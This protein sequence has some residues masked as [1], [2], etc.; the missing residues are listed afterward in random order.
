MKDPHRFGEGLG[1][2]LV[3]AALVTAGLSYLWQHGKRR[4]AIAIA[5]GVV[6][7]ITAITWTL[8][9]TFGAGA[10]V[11]PLT[12]AERAPLTLSRGKLEHPTLHFTLEAPGVDFTLAGDEGARAIAAAMPGRD[13]VTGWLYRCPA[14]GEAVLV[15]LF[16]SVL[17]SRQGLE[18]LVDGFR[19]SLL[20]AGGAAPTLAGDGVVWTASERSASFTATLPNGPTVVCRFV[21]G[22]TYVAGVMATLADTRRAEDLAGSLALGAL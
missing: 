3:F 11:T 12:A 13:D 5:V 7:L 1:R 10:T 15:M 18:G 16:K 20:S 22:P 21:A 6:A 19:Q 9:G 17:D 14:T 8:L 4:L 2:L